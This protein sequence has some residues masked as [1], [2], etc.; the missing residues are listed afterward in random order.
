MLRERTARQT[1]KGAKDTIEAHV[2]QKSDGRVTVLAP[3]CERSHGRYDFPLPEEVIK[4]LSLVE[5]LEARPLALVRHMLSSRS[6]KR[7]NDEEPPVKE[8]KAFEARVIIQD[9]KRDVSRNLSPYF[10]LFTRTVIGASVRNKILVL[11]I[12]QF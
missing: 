3:A 8:K 6:R 1:W 2:D 4:S 12:T 5:K 7:K 11:I 9:S 10:N